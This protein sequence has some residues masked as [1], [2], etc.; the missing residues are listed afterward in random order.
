MSFDNAIAF[1][2]PKGTYCNEAALRFAARLGIAEPELIEC[3]S[4]DEVFDCV[5]EGVARFGV[6]GKENSLEG[7]VTATLDNFAFRTDAVILA[8]EVI[9]VD[10]CLVAHPTAT[11]ETIERVASHPQGLA[12]CR[13]FLRTSL[14]DT[15][16]LAVS[17]TAE[18]ARMAAS[19]PAVAGIS[20]RLAAEVH[21]AQILVPSIQ[22]NPENQ[23][24][25]ALVGRMADE[26][27]LTGTRYKTSLALFLRADKPG[28]LQMIL[29][30]F[31]YA[32]I[33]LTM[34]QSRPTK[35]Q[36]GDYMF[37]VELGG[38]IHDIDVQTALECLRLKLRE[39]KVLGSYP[40]E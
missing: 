28:A 16:T 29:S 22:D 1:L 40:I 25:F 35:K 6:V 26:N 39:V 15:P 37:F 38:S 20:N 2:G 31:T 13:R 5:D 19:D 11:L 17:S 18:S 21:G 14:P 23:T 27:L 8:E 33:N 7:P 4:F 24:A 10:H 12:Q 36:L 3:T 32:G 9:D 34:L 30:E